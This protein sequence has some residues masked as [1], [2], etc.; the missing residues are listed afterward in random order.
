M[1]LKDILKYQ[2][3]GKTVW[4]KLNSTQRRDYIYNAFLEKG[5]KPIQAASIVGNLQQENATFG[6]SV[7]NANSKAK[8]TGIAQ[9]LGSRKKNLMNDYKE[10]YDID[11]QIDFIHREIQGDRDAWTNNVGGKKAF[12]NAT[13][14]ETATKVFRKDFE[15]PGEH[16]ANDI[17]RIKNAYAVIGKNYTPPQDQS[18]LPPI[19]GGSWLTY[20]EGTP[21][22]ST[23][24]DMNFWSLPIDIQSTIIENQKLESERINQEIVANEWE[25]ENLAIEAGLKQKQL[26]RQQVLSTIP[27]AQYVGQ[28][29]LQ[30]NPLTLPQSNVEFMQQGGWVPFSER[31]VNPEAI[32]GFYQ[33]MVSAPWYKERL[34]KN[35]YNSKLDPSNWFGNGAQSEVDYRLKRLN[36]A[37]VNKIDIGKLPFSAQEAERY[38]ALN[39]LGT[40]WNPASNE[41]N[42]KLKDSF[43]NQKKVEPYE[44]VAHEFGHPESAYRLNEYESNL[45]TSRL[46]NRTKDDHDRDPME[47]K[48][49]INVL[50]YNL[51]RKGLYDPNTGNYKTKSGKFET[52]LLDNV[53]SQFIIKRL[54]QNYNPKDLEFLVNT[55]AFNDRSGENILYTQM[56]GRVD[57]GAINN[58]LSKVNPKNWFKEDYSQYKTYGEAYQKARQDGEKEF[59]YK[60]KRYTTSYKGTPAQQLKETG[61]TDS[62]KGTR[63]IVTE[64]LANNLYPG[65]YNDM[66]SRVKS[67]V[68]DNKKEEERKWMDDSSTERWAKNRKDAFN[69]YLGKP[70]TDNTFAVS[71]YRPSVEKNKNTTYY[72]INENNF[73]YGDGNIFQNLMNDIQSKSKMT[74]DKPLE[75]NLKKVSIDSYGNIMGDFTISTGKDERG[76][77]ISYYDLWDLAPANF[78]KP[79][80]IYDRFYYNIY[81]DKSGKPYRGQMYYNDTELKTL[82]LDD[83]NINIRKLQ[84]ELYQRGYNLTNSIKKDKNDKNNI[85]F[86]GILGNETRTALQQY[87]NDQK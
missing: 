22:P 58:I 25:K 28:T 38:K 37:K 26:E 67:T 8:P 75:N 31:Q 13:D 47:N 83:K 16:E 43:L 51:F 48:A 68:V 23:T 56:G 59:L 53:K 33:D 45:L 35:G 11:N 57:A 46:S 4:N 70:Q 27:Q 34:E 9:W 78:G 65:G 36:S 81:K 15:R 82:S 40:N 30:P 76:N 24:S 21:L 55:I 80:E 84:K 29:K 77:Y 32:R 54:Q 61:I 73:Y 5:Y 10:W 6:T 39:Q 41:I 20:N 63:N 52:K 79:Y 85:V 72:K 71:D 42:Y 14:I 64:R 19:N 44:V 87:R 60:D 74:S 50:R 18:N 2:M 17:R 62:Q 69:L 7:Q 3:G 49:D 1:V 66:I 12:L 86:D